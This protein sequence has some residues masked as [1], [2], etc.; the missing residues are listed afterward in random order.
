LVKI[1]ILKAKAKDLVEVDKKKDAK[2]Y[3]D[4]ADKIKKQMEV[5]H[6]IYLRIYSYER[7]HF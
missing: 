6:N 2:R 7:K 4:E 3:T 1:D 5:L